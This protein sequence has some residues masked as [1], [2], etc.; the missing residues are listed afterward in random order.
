M[1]SLR[2]LAPPAL[3]LVGTLGAFSVGACSKEEAPPPAA[4]TA[5]PGEPQIDTRQLNQRAAAPAALR[6]IMASASAAASAP[7][8]DPKAALIGTWRFSGFD[9]TDTATKAMWT[10]LAG[11]AQTEV[12]GDASKATLTITPTELVTRLGPE[13]TRQAYAIDGA[14]DAGPDELSLR[15]KDGVKAVRFVDA[16]RTVMRVAEPGKKDAPVTLFARLPPGATT[17]TVSA[18]SAPSAT[19][20][21]PGSASK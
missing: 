19:A 17:T 2:W 10:S 8:L 21:A 12:L 3:V 16:A 13:E 4:T 6:S 1:P 9:M 14:A 20:K 18:A 7:P 5:A 15:T 11:S